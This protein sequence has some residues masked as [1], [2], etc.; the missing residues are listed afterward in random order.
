[1][2]Q[3][4]VDYQRVKDNNI[5]RL[6]ADF[7]R[8][9]YLNY[10]QQ[11]NKH[12]KYFLKRI[13][14]PTEIKRI[15]EETGIQILLAQNVR[16]NELDFSNIVF[17]NESVKEELKRNKLQYDDV[18]LTRSGANFGQAAA[19]KQNDEVYACADVLVIK[20]SREIKGGYLS[21]FFN[22]KQGRALLDRGS[23]GMAQPHIAPSY[24]YSLPIPRFDTD[25]ENRI[26]DL[27]NKAESYKF[28][29]LD[30]YSQAEQLLLSELGFLDWKSEHKL[31][32]TVNLSAAKKAERFD[33]EYFQPKYDEIIKVVENYKGGFDELG[34]LAEIK[35]KNFTPKNSQQYKY[36][37]LSSISSNGE[38]SS[39]AEN[40]GKEL[41]SRARRKVQKDDVIISS[42]EGS[43]KSIAL[44]YENWTDALCSTGFFVI[45]SKKINSETMLVLLKTKIGQLQLKKGCRGTILTAIG[46]EEFSKIILPK[47]NPKIQNKIKEKILKMY[48]AKKVSKE[49]LETAKRCIEIAIEENEGEA[50]VY[51]N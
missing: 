8:A 2:Q 42:I 10:L 21:T 18:I 30:L 13:L 29:S 40:F 28:N 17:M 49:L 43:L 31:T 16:N 26:D 32:F 37:E 45:N 14:H 1:M 15:Y 12:D 27:V 50:L 39:Y 4:V 38:I 36:I 11:I 20:N 41:P 25:F 34:N 19:Y 47:I 9:D 35:D 3:S 23:Y 7:Y 48:E 5:F 6:D 24:L 33:A 51:L 46:K 22:T 44:I